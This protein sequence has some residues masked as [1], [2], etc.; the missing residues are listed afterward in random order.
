MRIAKPSE[1]IVAFGAARL[2]SLCEVSSA[3]VARWHRKKSIPEKQLIKIGLAYPH[4]LIIDDDG[5]PWWIDEVVFNPP[6]W[7][8]RRWWEAYVH[9]RQSEQMGVE[10]KDL[11][12]VVNTLNRLSRQGYDPGIVLRHA[13]V[14]RLAMPVAASVKE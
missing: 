7:V 3:S 13:V 12:E 5:V 6:D 10:E 9:M 8:P 14:N 1:I 11:N 2:Q 4:R